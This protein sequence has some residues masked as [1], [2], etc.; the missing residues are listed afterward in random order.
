MNY[1]L[2]IVCKNGCESNISQIPKEEIK[3]T[4]KTISKGINTSSLITLIHKDNFFLIDG[5]DISSVS[6][7]KIESSDLFLDNITKNKKQKQVKFNATIESID[8]ENE[9]NDNFTNL[10]EVKPTTKL[11]GEDIK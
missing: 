9:E 3:D 2:R 1:N 11:I 8:E 4:L 7:E 5:Q 10:L 6:F